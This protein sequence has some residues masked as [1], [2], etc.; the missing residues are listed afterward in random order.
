MSIIA[1]KFG[2]LMREAREKLGIS[3]EQLAAALKISRVSIA[4]YETGKQLPN[5]DSALDIAA[6]LKLSLDKLNSDLELSNLQNSLNRVEDEEL[7]DQ[8][9]SLI[10]DVKR[11]KELDHG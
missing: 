3:Q 7:R 8:L 11:G 1:R 10:S 5:L 4:N 9:N 2:F 6:H